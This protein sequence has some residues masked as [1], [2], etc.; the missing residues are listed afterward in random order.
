[1][2]VPVAAKTKLV[3]VGGTAELPD[4]VKSHAAAIERIAR[5]DGVERAQTV[6]AG[7]AQIVVG[8]AT[9]ALPLAG[10]IDFSAE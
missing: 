6:P 2:N 9:F 3:I 4:R 8:G 1:M 7:S 5:V 10:V